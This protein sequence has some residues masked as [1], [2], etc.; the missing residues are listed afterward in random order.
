MM[1]LA[2]RLLR[3]GARPFNLP[4]RAHMRALLAILGLVPLVCGAADR[5]NGTWRSDHDASIQFAESHAIL[6][7]RQLEF[8]NGSLGRLEMSFG[9]EEMR[10]RL[11]DFD[12]TIQGKL[13]HMVGADESFSYRVLGVDKDSV[14]ILVAKYQGRDR[15]LHIHFVNDDTFWLYSEETDFGLRDLNFREYFRKTK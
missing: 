5:L 4:V 1:C 13:R 3:G 11:P 7:P 2:P 14:A 6:E 12:L 8:L 10:Y 15:I 9:G